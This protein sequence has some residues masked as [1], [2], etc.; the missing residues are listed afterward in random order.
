MVNY[1]IRLLKEVPGH[2]DWL[3][4]SELE[5]VHSLRFEKRRNDWLL[6]RW[7]AKN[8]LRESWFLDRELAQ[9]AILPRE[10]KAPF[11]FLNGVQ[12]T[13]I[14][15]ISHSHG[16]SFCVTSDGSFPVGCDLEKVARRSEPF[17]NDYFTQNE[18]QLF[19]THDQELTKE[20]F[21]TLLW[22]AKE[23]L[24]K[25]T[26]KGMSLHP[27]KIEVSGIQLKKEGWNRLEL[28]EHASNDSFTG[29]WTVKNNFI[30]VIVFDRVLNGVPV[31]NT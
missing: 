10:N 5:I 24:M 18:H 16:Q 28:K 14:I 9:L 25:A 11:V 1:S 30:F 26:R 29:Y 17:L 27:M 21:Y 4:P 19:Q 7:T 3:H 6:G 31:K 13:C 22:S 8:L 23:A 15:S 20:V 2:L 12:Q